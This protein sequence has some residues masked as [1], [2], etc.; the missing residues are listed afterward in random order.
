MT[1][2]DTKDRKITQ[3]M[4]KQ[5]ITGQDK[6]DRMGQDTQKDM[7]K[8]VITGQDKQDRM[9]KD[10]QKDMTLTG[11]NKTKTKLHTT[12]VNSDRATLIVHYVHFIQ[13]PSPPP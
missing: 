6:Q 5:V 9:G 7:T 3:D 13:P 8:Q 4:T 12:E 10:T 1:K 2:R 11:Q